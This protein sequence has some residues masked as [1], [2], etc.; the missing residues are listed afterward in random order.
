MNTIIPALAASARSARP[1]RRRRSGQSS[2]VLL[3]GH[4]HLGLG[5]GLPWPDNELILDAAAA[6][7]SARGLFQHQCVRACVRNPS[8]HAV[9]MG[10]PGSE[11]GA[12]SSGRRHAEKWG[13]NL[14]VAKQLVTWLGSPTPFRGGIRMPSCP[15]S[16]LSSSPPSA[17]T[18]ERR[19][20]GGRRRKR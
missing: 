5:L 11:D 17:R 15:A 1:S 10:H 8:I 6:R 19:W 3:D 2:S 4:T 16:A 9:H 14:G 7:P 20:S 12:S 13:D 18:G